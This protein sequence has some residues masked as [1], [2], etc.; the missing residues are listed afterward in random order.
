M[1]RMMNEIPAFFRMMRQIRRVLRMYHKKE[2]NLTLS[3]STGGPGG[4]YARWLYH[5]AF[6]PGINESSSC[7][8]SLAFG[9]F[10]VVNFDHS[11]KCVVHC[12]NLHFPVDMM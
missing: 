7:S 3:D 11:N 6:L 4:H 5:F 2:G 10:S 12:F 8:K 1:L 9:I